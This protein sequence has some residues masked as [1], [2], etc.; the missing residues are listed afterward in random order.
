MVGSSGKCEPVRI[1]SELH[2]LPTVGGVQRVVRG[3]SENISFNKQLT[4]LERWINVQI[5]IVVIRVDIF[6]ESDIV[7]HSRLVH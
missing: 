7:N 2:T 1:L 5:F 6:G 3:T 4:V